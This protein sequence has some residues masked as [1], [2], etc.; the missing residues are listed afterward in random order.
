M[1]SSPFLAS[2]MLKVL[3]ASFSKFRMRTSY[4]M[5]I[6][7]IIGHEYRGFKVGNI[8]INQNYI[9]VNL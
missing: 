7:M 5:V 2:R 8:Q 4:I 9:L 1:A 3:E 6:E